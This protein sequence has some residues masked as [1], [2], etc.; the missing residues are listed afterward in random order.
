MKGPHSLTFLFRFQ[1][2]LHHLN[3]VNLIGGCWDDGPDKLCIVL[4]FCQNGS[5]D[6]LLKLR[7]N[8]WREPYFRIATGIV[9]CFVYLH[10]EQPKE[11]LIHRDLK[12][13]N[14][15]I[16]DDISAKVADFGES[17]RFDEAEAAAREG[18]DVVT[19]VSA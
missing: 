10:H 15:L 2:P 5:L 18:Q 11:P 8:T 19:M 13:A 9:S 12:P 17:T 3:L 6:D 1:A 14:V 16:A 7:E 4:E